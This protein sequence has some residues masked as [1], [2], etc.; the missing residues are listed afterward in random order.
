MALGL[1]NYRIL[2]LEKEKR[3]PAGVTELGL[4]C[5]RGRSETCPYFE[6]KGALLQQLGQL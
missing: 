6:G 3:K 1:P 5:E 2:S 4:N